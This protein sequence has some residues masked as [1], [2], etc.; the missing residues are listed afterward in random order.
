MCAGREHRPARRQGHPTDRLRGV[1]VQRHAGVGARGGRLGDRL[2]R[3]HLVTGRD[4]R[5]QGDP[6]GADRVRPG[7]QLQPAQPVD[8]DRGDVATRRGVP[9]RGVQ[10][11]GV[12][13]RRVHQRRAD[14]PPTRQAAE[15]RAVRRRR[16]A[17][18]EGELV[19]ADAER[20]RGRLAGGVEQL[21][22]PTGL[23]VELAGIGPAVLEGGQQGLPGD[24]MQRRGGR[25]VQVD[26]GCTHGS[27]RYIGGMP[28][29]PPLG[30]D[31]DPT[32]AES[33][34]VE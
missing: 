29:V 34:M 33:A 11:R 21:P 6:G 13:D 30:A 26:R 22:G 24:R 10:H 18:G 25:R 19:G 12:L 1:D 9:L 31:S 7:G 32:T 8:R 5:R 15:H 16:T 17:G 4:Q 28:K 27:L 23:G 2:Y 20:L 3:A 14:P